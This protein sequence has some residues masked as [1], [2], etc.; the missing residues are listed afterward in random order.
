MY[1][2]SFL[3]KIFI[4]GSN[5]IKHVLPAALNSSSFLQEKYSKSIKNIN[6]TSKNFSQDFVFLKIE[7]NEVTNPYKLLPSLFTNWSQEQLDNTISE[8]GEINNGGAAL[9]AYAKLQYQEMS[10]KERTEIEKGLLKYC[11]LDTLA[12][13]M[14]YEYFKDIITTK[15]V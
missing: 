6:L 3:N 13:V 10:I 7:N 1:L 12:M 9:V 8:L 2:A 15:Y 11:E 4:K 5:S 14:I